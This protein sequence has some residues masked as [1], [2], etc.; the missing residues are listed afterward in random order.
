[1]HIFRNAS[2]YVY[3][4]IV[5]ADIPGLLSLL[6]DKNIALDALQTV[7]EMTIRARFFYCDVAA[8]RRLTGKRGDQ[9]VII[10]KEGLYWNGHRFLNRPILSFLLVFII[11]MSIFLPTRIFFVRIEG[12]EEI[13]NRRILQAAEECGI[14]MFSS[15]RKVRSENVKNRLLESIPELQWVGVNTAGCIA[16]ISVAEKS[17]QNETLEQK[18][19]VSSI[20]AS[21]AGVIQACTVTRGNSLCYV[22]QAVNA[23]DVLVSGYTDCG[24]IVKATQAEAEILARTS[25]QLEVL[26]PGV[27]SKRVNITDRQTNFS[28]LFGKKLVKLKKCSGIS[29][30]TCVKIYNEYILTLPGGFSLPI[31]L[32]REQKIFYAYAETDIHSDADWLTDEA[33]RYLKTQMIAGQILDQNIQV[34]SEENVCVLSGQ[35]E[36]LE[37]IGQIKVEDFIQR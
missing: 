24:I 8:I 33:V 35:F 26:S 14:R 1:M 12:N 23:G 31:G 16:T 37:M 27:T 21:R 30:A 4:E 19:E 3:A 10:R 32:I 18:A 25:R 2:G 29:D 20:V 34:Q 9:F 7:D 28:I 13:P 11:L 6:C 17:V 15:R 22:G 5:S 36:C